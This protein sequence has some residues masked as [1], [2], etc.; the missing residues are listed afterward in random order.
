MLLFVFLSFLK[1]PFI[2]CHCLIE[3]Q[4]ING[5]G[6]GKGILILNFMFDFHTVTLSF[7][8]F[9]RCHQFSEQHCG[10]IDVCKI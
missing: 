8:S 6:K 9:L 7:F 2:P 1:A 4:Q 5:K 3:S 10:A